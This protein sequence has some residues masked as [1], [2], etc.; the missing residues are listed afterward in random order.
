MEEVLGHEEHTSNSGEQ[1]GAS[2]GCMLTGVASDEREMDMT[3]S[4][5]RGL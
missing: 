5:K 1:G 3:P 4:L 2:R